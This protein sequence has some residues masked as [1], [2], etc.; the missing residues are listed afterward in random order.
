MSIYE[1]MKYLLPLIQ[2]YVYTPKKVAHN[3]GPQKTAKLLILDGKLCGV[4]F[5]SLI[6]S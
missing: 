1:Y 5:R 3:T 6:I 2:Q 4:N